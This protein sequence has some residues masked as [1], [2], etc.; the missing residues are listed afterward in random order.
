MAA[1][2]VAMPLATFCWYAGCIRSAMSPE[3][4]ATS[5]AMAAVVDLPAGA[6]AHCQRP[7][8]KLAPL[9]FCGDILRRRLADRQ[10]SGL[11]RVP[12]DEGPVVLSSR[13]QQ[14]GVEP[15]AFAVGRGVQR[16]VNG[17]MRSVGLGG[18]LIER[19]VDVGVA[20]H[21]GRNTTRLEFLTQAAG[22]GER[23]VFFC[24]RIAESGAAV[25]P[26][27]ARIDDG[28]VVRRARRNGLRSIAGDRS[29]RRVRRRAV[30]WAGA[31]GCCGTGATVIVRPSLLKLAIR[32]AFP[33]TVTSAT[34]LFST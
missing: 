34:P 31:A 17:R 23:D 12:R 19:D 20:Q 30:V 16:N 32:G 27:M 8:R 4:G 1:M 14:R 26:A 7:D 21:Q 3:A 33:F 22:E 18:A 10:G 5:T 15:D 24:E 9:K 11:R 6:T 25:I 13:G 28:I 29:G 2:A